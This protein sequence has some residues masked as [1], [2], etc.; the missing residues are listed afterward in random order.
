M[1]THP[2]PNHLPV[3][4]DWLSRRTEPAL[5]PGLPIIDAHHHLLDRPDW[6][7]VAD[8]F[9]ADAGSGHNIVGSVF[10]QCLTAYRETG[11]DHLKPVGETEYVA[12][13]AAEC[14]KSRPQIALG[15][16]GHADLRRG[17]AVR[18]VLEAHMAAGRGRFR[19]IRDIVVWDQD[20]SLLNP[21]RDVPPGLMDD[22]SFRAGFAELAPLGLTFDAWLFHPQIDDLARLAA[23]FPSTRLVLDHFGGVVGIGPYRGRRGE[24]LASWK[25]SI[26]ALSQR[27]NVYVKLGGLGMRINGFGFE[28]QDDPPASEQLATAWRPYVETCIERFGAERCMFESNFPAD[29]GSCAYGVCWNAFKRLTKDASVSERAALFH[30]TARRFYSLDVPEVSGKLVEPSQQ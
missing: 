12:A 10:V 21:A 11:P 25:K 27:G 14:G 18:E 16:V 5:D 2:N 6:R 9:G 3:R 17:A 8:D 1:S 24:I 4:P 15:I 29:K 28:N 13:V 20:R 23:D 22:A 19:G 7:Y 26:A 30:D